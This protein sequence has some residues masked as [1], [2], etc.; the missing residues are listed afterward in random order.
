MQQRTIS[1]FARPFYIMAKPAGATCNLNCRYCY[2]L[3]KTKL[4]AEPRHIMSD[5]LL[6]KYVKEYI[7]A[8]TTSDILFTWHGGETLLRPVE[9]YEKAI[10]LQRRYGRG[11][12]IDNVIQTNGTL[13]DERW[14]RFF[15][16]NGWLVGVSI[17]G[18]QA[19]HD[20][21]R[22]TRTGAPTFD[23]VMRG[24][25]ILNDCHVQWNAM[26]AI[27]NVN[28]RH[29]LEFYHFFKSIGCHYIQFTPVVERTAEHSNG[30]LLTS[31]A[32]GGAL[33]DYSVDAVEWGRFLCTIFD[34]W[35]RKDVGEY[36]V[37]FFDAI[38]A[39]W[40]GVAPGICSMAPVCGQAAAMEY[41][42][43]VYS[44]DHFVFPE[45]RLGNIRDASLYALMNGE[46][47][48]TFGAAKRDR[49]PRQCRECRFLFACN[50]EC[51]KNRFL[52]TDD[53]E[54]G[55][56]YLCQ[57]YRQFFVHSEPYFDFMAAELRAGRAPANVME[58]IEAGEL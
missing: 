24:I 4:Y 9:F 32:E 47:Q 21:Y 11:R 5:A 51:P 41:N 37:P 54:R 39:N 7:E 29:P 26:A 55:L 19:L 43:D 22:R 2:Y 12:N 38:L 23:M 31:A 36:F 46:R 25:G 17:D 53:G 57:G 40:V 33:T 6:E 8:Q 14:A 3:E 44:C 58:A 34:E 10:A 42:G 1:P 48:L 56:N 13:I 52:V 50:G 35:V 49:L 20:T 30:T 15:A 45:Y 27:N 28:S 18:P 16:D